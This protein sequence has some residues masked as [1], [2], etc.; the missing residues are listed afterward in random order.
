MNL[1]IGFPFAFFYAE[2]KA[3]T[4]SRRWAYVRKIVKTLVIVGVSVSYKIDLNFVQYFIV[5]GAIIYTRIGGLT[6]SHNMNET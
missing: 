5:K 4:Y 6:V 1:T 3:D 2:K